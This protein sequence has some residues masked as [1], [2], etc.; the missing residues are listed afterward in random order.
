VTARNQAGMQAR[1]AVAFALPVGLFAAA[2]AYLVV[3]MLPGRP[4]F[5]GE[6]RPSVENVNYASPLEL[7]FSPTVSDSMCCAR[8]AMK[9]GFWMPRAMW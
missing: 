6:N 8:A 1:P 5:A 2:L 4:V 3:A 7:T 9:S